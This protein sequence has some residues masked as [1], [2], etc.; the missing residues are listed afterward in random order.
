MD[1]LINSV[2]VLE[3][4]E[5]NNN[6][7]N[8][9]SRI[10]VLRATIRKNRKA[11]I[12]A[13][14]YSVVFVFTSLPFASLIAA[15]VATSNTPVSCLTETK[16]IE[17]KVSKVLSG[18]TFT[19][20]D[21]RVVKLL[22]IEAPNYNFREPGYSEN[23]AQQAKQYL[24]ELLPKKILV[25][26][27]LDN[28]KQDRYGHILASVSRSVDKLDVV[29]DLLQSG[30]ARQIVH[31]PNDSNWR[32]YQALEQQAQAAHKGLWKYLRYWPRITK[33]VD[34]SDAGYLRLFGEVTSVKRSRR[35]LTLILDDKIWLGIKL[36]DIKNFSSNLEF[37]YLHK[38]IDV[39]GWLYFSNE[40][41][42]I[43]IRHPQQLNLF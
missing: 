24:S 34:K 3:A 39:R 26:L 30:W 4:V 20:V 10:V 38:K 33:F 28:K 23:G 36:S 40:K 22:G 32:C 6:H 35:Y 2:N 12:G 41:L 8:I 17:A 5:L 25:K 31:P 19:L 7:H 1:E 15:E 11:L 43:R 9:D 16:F 18:D 29:A 27:F 13:F 21:G 42:R 37:E 14:F